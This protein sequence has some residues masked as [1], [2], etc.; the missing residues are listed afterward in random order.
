MIRQFFR[1]LAGP[2]K[3]L[4]GLAPQEEKMSHMQS[5]ILANNCQILVF[6]EAFE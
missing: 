2:K 3:L 4:L 1:I 6:A 5:K